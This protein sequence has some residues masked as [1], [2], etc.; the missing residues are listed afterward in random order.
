MEE[1]AVVV[2]DRFEGAAVRH[3]DVVERGRVV[4]AVAAV[5]DLDRR[6]AAGDCF[7]RFDRVMLDGLDGRVGD[8]V[9]LLDVEDRERAEEHV[10]AVLGFGFAGLLDRLP[11]HDLRSLLALADRAAAVLCLLERHPVGRRVAA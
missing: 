3:P 4:G 7:A 1:R 5:L 8:V 9:A 6:V 11:E 10:V 2:L